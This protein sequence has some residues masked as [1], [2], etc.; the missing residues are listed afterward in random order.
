L[1]VFIATEVIVV[2]ARVAEN[3]H[4]CV[5]VANKVVGNV[6]EYSNTI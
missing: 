4:N 5:I 6:R 1:A 2:F 3:V